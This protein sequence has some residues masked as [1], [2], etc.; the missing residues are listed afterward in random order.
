MTRVQPPTT[1]NTCSGPNHGNPDALPAGHRR[2][3]AGLCLSLTQ[4]SPEGVTHNIF[5]TPDCLCDWHG[6]FT[7][8]LE[9]AQSEEDPP[10]HFILVWIGLSGT[11]IGHYADWEELTQHIG[12]YQMDLIERGLI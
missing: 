3:R 1:P 10:G 8:L 7:A 9:S 6:Y 4:A 11:T 5:C 12:K 2:W